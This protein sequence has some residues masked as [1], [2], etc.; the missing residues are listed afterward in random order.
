MKAAVAAGIEEGRISLDPGIGF[1]KTVT[2]NLELLNRLDEIVALGRPV[3]V[4]T[5]RKRFIGAIAG[6][7]P[8]E[9][10]PG[11]LASI[12]VALERGARIFRVHDVAP[13]LAALRVAAATFR[14]SSWETETT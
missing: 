3:L 9:R 8:E 2:H 4:G 12:V 7:E 14:P 13:S 5:S 6:G 10:V 11:S 1:G